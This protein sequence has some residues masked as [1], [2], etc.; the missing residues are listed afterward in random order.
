[1]NYTR[2]PIIESVISPK[3]GCKLAIR[4]SKNIGEEYFVDAI[5]IVSFSNAVFYRSKERP[6]E[7]LVPVSDYEVVEVKETKMVLKNATLDRSIKIASS[8]SPLVKEE[9]REIKKKKNIKRP[10]KKVEPP[11]AVADIEQLAKG[12]EKDEETV[13][14]S[15]TIRKIF[16]PPTGLIKE[17]LNHYKSDE[18]DQKVISE[19]IVSKKEDVK[20][21]KKEIEDN[22]IDLEREKIKKELIDKISEEIKSS[23]ENN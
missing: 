16:P 19:E 10:N 23:E 2:E 21:E 22:L 15:S 17:K 18:K 7:F 14:S 3:E 20:L 12:G 4:N 6:K 5:E 9:E 13:V 11:R 1:V 8:N